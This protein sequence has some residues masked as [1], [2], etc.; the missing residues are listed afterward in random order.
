MW[1]CIL[2]SCSGPSWIAQCYGT[3]KIYGI[4]QHIRKLPFIL[5]SH[6]GHIG[7][8]GQIGQIKKEPFEIATGLPSHKR[9]KANYTDIFSTVMRKMGDRDE[10]VTAITAAMPDGIP[11]GGSEC[12]RREESDRRLFAERRSTQEADIALLAVGSMVKIAEEV[13][14]ILKDTGYNCTLVNARFVKPID[15]ECLE[16]LAKT[17]RLFVTMEENVRSGGYGL[18][19]IGSN[20]TLC[21][22]FRI[23]PHFFKKKGDV[24]VLHVFVGNGRRQHMDRKPREMSL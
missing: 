12:R 20:Y 18:S 5:G 1:R 24:S 9:T 15:T 10:K 14:K 23:Q 13:R 16:L 11:P 7:N 4:F 19:H 3:L 22:G 2:P 17:H 6:N 8:A 21:N